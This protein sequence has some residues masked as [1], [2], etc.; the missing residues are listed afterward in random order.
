M[1]SS[2]REGVMG[3]L[4]EPQ[5]DTS[6]TGIRPV[7]RNGIG[8]TVTPD[9]AQVVPGERMAVTLLV[10]NFDDVAYTCKVAIAGLSRSWYQVGA[11]HPELAPA[12]T[13]GI[14][15]IIHPPAAS[16]IAHGLYLVGVEVTADDD[17]AIHAAGIIELMVGEGP[18]LD[19]ALTPLRVT[20]RTAAFDVTIQNLMDWPA[21]VSLEV[22]DAENV[23]AIDCAPDNV[24]MVQPG[25]PRTVSVRA[26]PVSRPAG[27]LLCAFDVTIRAR[28]PGQRAGRAIVTRQVRVAF[29]SGSSRVG[30]RLRGQRLP[31]WAIVVPLVLAL[32][33]LAGI[34]GRLLSARSHNSVVRPGITAGAAPPVRPRPPAASP[35]VLVNPSQLDLGR[36]GAQRSN[37][38]VIH[39][40]NLGVQPLRIGR[41]AVVG[42]GARDFVAR[43]VCTRASLGPQAGCTIRVRYTAR[44]SR[45]SRAVLVVSGPAAGIVR[46]VP[47]AGHR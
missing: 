22:S 40:V 25:V 31:R 34:A 42:D 37:T 19:M 13:E 10:Q 7:R 5:G 47:L 14:G 18:A 21:P 43:T 20:G 33:L 26:V 1:T 39:I 23:L 4:E 17:P 44:S 8:L 32:I 6:S 27:N 24:V 38:A 9:A 3:M 30:L 2:V 41:V 16:P 45:A 11:S 15:L 28:L 35:D 46:R 36:S 29:A 12:A